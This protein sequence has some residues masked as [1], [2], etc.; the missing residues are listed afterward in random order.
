MCCKSMVHN[1]KYILMTMYYYYYYD[2]NKVSLR[3]Q[4]ALKER[5][6][7]FKKEF[8]YLPR[9][10]KRADLY[11]PYSIKIDGK[12]IV[13][14][15]VI[16]I[17]QRLFFN[18]VNKCFSFHERTKKV[19]DKK[20]YG[21]YI[22]I[23]D[24]TISDSVTEIQSLEHDFF[25]YHI[26]NFISSKIEPVDG[27]FQKNE[28]PAIN[29]GIEDNKIN[30]ARIAFS[31]GNCTL[32]LGAG[33]SASAGIPLWN[34][35]LENMLDIIKSE[36]GCNIS[37]SDIRHIN[38]SCGNSSIIAGRF[39]KTLKEK[40]I[41]D[42]RSYLDILKKALYKDYDDTKGSELLSQI[43]FMIKSGN[44]KG[45]ITYNFDDL[46]ERKL[47]D[48]GEGIC[49]PVYGNSSPENKIPI[50]HVHGYVPF[51]NENISPTAVLAEDEYHKVYSDI[52]SWSNI[53][54][55]HALSRS[56]CFFIGF[57]MTDPNQRRLLDISY[58]SSDKELRH[59]V[60][61]RE[62]NDFCSLE[63]SLENKI[64]QE[65]MINNLGLNVIWFKNFEELP[66]ILHELMS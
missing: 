28:T 16:E 39:I 29:N 65:R 47:S 46:L 43:C 48:D 61:L 25:V 59:Y 62:T 30:D 21:S 22:L 1:L 54:Q 64:I 49:Y 36:G 31:E 12:E 3:V 19:E 33:V 5:N 13:G 26:N 45:V 55:L 38:E 42:N 9:S 14:P 18:T 57:S 35:L 44:V 2:E 11:I 20:V 40:R 10:N 51:K 37:K 6:I 58:S 4:D 60:F 53:E 15:I 41:K 17:K 24:E 56:T 34:N 7:E 50:F 63:K 66:I 27:N 32:F 23:Y 8:M 52:Y